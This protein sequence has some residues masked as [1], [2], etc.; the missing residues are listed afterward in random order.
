MSEERLTKLEMTIAEQEATIQDLS[1]VVNQQWLE[2]EK[3]QNKLKVTH[4]R[5]VSLEENLPADTHVEKP[6]HY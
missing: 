6:P 5:I 1:D 2:I 3:L 4:S